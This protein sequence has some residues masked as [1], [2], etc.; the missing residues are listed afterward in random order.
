MKKKKG[1]AKQARPDEYEVPDS[2]QRIQ[3][4]PRVLR[5]AK[6]VSKQDTV[7]TPTRK[8]RSASKTAVAKSSAAKEKESEARRNVVAIS[9]SPML[10]RG[11]DNDGSSSDASDDKPLTQFQS[12]FP[13]YFLTAN[14]SRFTASLSSSKTFKKEYYSDTLWFRRQERR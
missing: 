7:A 8:P 3:T 5:S 4:S 2:E 13:H 9:P 10:P 14:H 6:V 1:S 12:R 11:H